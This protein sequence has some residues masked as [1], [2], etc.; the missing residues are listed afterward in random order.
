MVARK[1]STPATEPN[2][3]RAL[4]ANLH[5]RPDTTVEAM[6]IAR[7][8][9]RDREALSDIERI[10]FGDQIVGTTYRADLRHGG[11]ASVADLEL[12]KIAIA[13][14]SHE[15][16]LPT[17][18][19]PSALAMAHLSDLGHRGLVDRDINGLNSDKEKSYR[20]PFDI[21]PISSQATYPA[22]WGHDADRERQLILAPDREGQIRPGME[23]EADAVWAT[24][25]RL[26]FNLRFPVEFAKSRRCRDRAP[27][28]WRTG[29]AQFSARR[30]NPRIRA[31]PLVEYDLGV[32]PF[33][34]ACKSSTSWAGHPHD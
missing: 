31:R 11:C 10:T 30:S 2:R 33:L 16:R 22:L 21:L 12:A 26:H 23:D 8:F 25:S 29:L 1:R 34:V 7:H 27:L 18:P 4:F 3:T 24:A 28:Y 13:L 17:L 32:I 5:R 20:G 9:R 14:E 6:E 19:Q 15:L